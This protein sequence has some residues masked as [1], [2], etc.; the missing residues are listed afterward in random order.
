MK[1][2]VI[3]FVKNFSA[4]TKF[5]TGSEKIQ[6]Y[7]VAKTLTS[8]MEGYESEMTEILTDLEKDDQTY[9]NRIAASAS[10][11]T[12]VAY[13]LAK[14]VEDIVLNSGDT[15]SS[16]KIHFT[17][18]QMMSKGSGTVLAGAQEILEQSSKYVSNLAGYKRGQENIDE[19]KEA[20]DQLIK[21]KKDLT[22]YNEGRQKKA[23]RL[24][25]VI[26]LAKKCVERADLFVETIRI[27]YPNIH[28]G[29]QDVRKSKEEVPHLSMIKILDSVTKEPVLEATVSVYSTTRMVNGQPLKIM[30]RKT[31]VNGL[32]RVDKAD[33]DVYRVVAKKVDRNDGE[34]MLIIAD[35]RPVVVEITMQKR[36]FN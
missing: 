25:V 27:D 24:D 32:I 33:Y 29:Y 12:R 19:L 7:P 3:A 17:Y 21:D 2:S 8:V 23:D 31:G 1:A 36:D 5:F 26:G 15:V 28:K 22:T 10:N 4:V 30:E 9:A 16:K 34:G 18:T 35:S 6:S 13:P 11:V 14:A 20:I